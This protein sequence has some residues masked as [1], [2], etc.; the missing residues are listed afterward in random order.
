MSNTSKNTYFVD[1]TRDIFG[2]APAEV[3]TLDKGVDDFQKDDTL[4]GLNE[5]AYSLQDGNDEPSLLLS[6][7]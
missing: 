4:L 7:I 2:I 3:E 6:Y 5:S 1:M